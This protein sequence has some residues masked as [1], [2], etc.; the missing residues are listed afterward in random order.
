MGARFESLTEGVLMAPHH[1]RY[2]QD[3]FNII[4]VTVGLAF[5]F[6]QTIL[7][8]QCAPSEPYKNLDIFFS[9][10]SKEFHAH[11]TGKMLRQ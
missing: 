2:T 5:F 9:P 10:R 8:E 1:S 7:H 3:E 4:S 11:G 6:I